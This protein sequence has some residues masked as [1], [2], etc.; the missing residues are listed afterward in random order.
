M[1]KKKILILGGNSGFIGRALAKK[2]PWAAIN[3]GFDLTDNLQTQKLL[4]SILPDTIYFLAAV[5]NSDPD[6]FRKNV[7]MVENV[8]N[9]CK[10]GAKIVFA[11]SNTV[12]GNLSA[13]N[14]KPAVPLAPKDYYYCSES[15][16]VN[17]TSPYGASKVACEALINSFTNQKKIKSV[18]LRFSAVVG[19]NQ[20][21]G[22][23]KDIYRKFK[24]DPKVEVFGASPGSVKNYLHVDD[25]V[26][27]LMY[28]GRHDYFNASTY[29]ITSEGPVSILDIVYQIARTAGLDKTVTWNYK[30][31]SPT[32]NPLLLMNTEKLAGLSWG[33]SY[34][35]GSI[36]IT[37]V[38]QDLEEL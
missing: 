19:P 7:S 9:N 31:A 27:A 28:F 8:L 30:A 24:N 22:A 1:S 33:P 2:L 14:Q 37:S 3:T 34:S 32:D 13:K 20:T 25:A 18:I 5:Q 15:D 35:S 4:N 26:S 10:P 29:N 38:I 16:P 23:L 11:S 6:C 36:A 21:H 12:Y 17:P